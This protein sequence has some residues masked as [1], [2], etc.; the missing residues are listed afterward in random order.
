MPS[1]DSGSHSRLNTITRNSRSASNWRRKRYVPRAVLQGWLAGRPQQAVDQRIGFAGPHGFE[2]T[3]GGDHPLARDA[4]SIPEGFDELDALARARGGDLYRHVA[5]VA[6]V[7]SGCDAVCKIT[8][9]YTTKPRQNITLCFY[10]AKRV[11]Y[12]NRTE[13][14]SNSG[15]LKEVLVPPG[16]S[17]M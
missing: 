15:G 11:K 5:T 16:C 12:A 13:K 17:S 10:K 1:L 2:T 14:L 8:C 6:P 4:G 7:S 3:E 9:H